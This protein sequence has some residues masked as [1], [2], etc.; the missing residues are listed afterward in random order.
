MNMERRTVEEFQFGQRDAREIQIP[1]AIKPLSRAAEQSV[2][3][4]DGYEMVGSGGL[5][6]LAG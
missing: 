5:A 2:V 1:C 4:L 6:G 3:L